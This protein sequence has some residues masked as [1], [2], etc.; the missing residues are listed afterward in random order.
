MLGYEQISLAENEFTT[1]WKSVATKEEK[2]SFLAE[3][4]DIVTDGGTLHISPQPYHEEAIGQTAYNTYTNVLYVFPDKVC[5]ILL[6]QKKSLTRMPL[7][8][9]SS[10]WRGTRSRQQRGLPTAYAF[11]PCRST[12]QKPIT[13][14]CRPLCF[15]EPWY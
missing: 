4:T 11:A 3:H 13:L 2:T 8:W 1:Q 5:G 15:T 14:S 9:K 7:N 12:V 6:Q 10:L